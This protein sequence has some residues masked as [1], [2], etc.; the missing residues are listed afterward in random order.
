MTT[1]G[2]ARTTHWTRTRTA[3]V[4][5]LIVAAVGVIIMILVGV[6]GIPLIP[7]GPIILLAAAGVVAWLRWRWSPAV[8]L[9]AALFLGVGAAIAPT[10]RAIMAAPSAI[11]PF[12]GSTVELAGLVVA[13]VAGAVAVTRAARQGG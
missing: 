9:L 2:T 8:G 11:G 12:V 4:A 7:P 3:Q 6:P 10:T 5:G 1:T 13:I